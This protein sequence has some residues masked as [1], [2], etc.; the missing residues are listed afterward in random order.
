M[1]IQIKNIDIGRVV[2]FLEKESFKGIESVMRSRLTTFLGGEFREVVQGEE[3]IRE[4]F[5]DDKK[6]RIEELDLYFDQFVT[7]EGDNMV[8]PLNVI[9]SRVKELTDEESDR[10]FEGSDAY[11][12]SILY[13]AFE[14]GGDE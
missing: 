9:K 12:L 5:K 1:R 2:E 10:E 13:E 6:L 14:L 8:K 3:I 4:D 11:A 7:V